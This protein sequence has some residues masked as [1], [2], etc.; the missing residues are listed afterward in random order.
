MIAQEVARRKSEP[1]LAAKYLN[2]LFGNCYT[3]RIVV[4]AVELR[5]EEKTT[6]TTWLG[7]QFSVQ[8]GEI[9]LVFG[10]SLR[11]ELKAIKC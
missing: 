6:T 3:V 11:E 2:C 10:K 8:V 4:V 7:R 5:R 9:C 1:A